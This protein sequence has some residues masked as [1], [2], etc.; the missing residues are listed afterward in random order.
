MRTWRLRHNPARHSL[1]AK[2]RAAVRLC[3]T[4][5]EAAA[6]P[7]HNAEHCAD[8]LTDLFEVMLGTGMFRVDGL[9]HR[10]LPQQG[11][12]FHELLAG[13][14]VD[15]WELGRFTPRSPRGRPTGRA[16]SSG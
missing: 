9:H 4:P 8:R 1:P 10:Q 5:D 11:V 3:G 12:E 13:A 14:A 7:R 6:F 2:P 16:T 15:Q